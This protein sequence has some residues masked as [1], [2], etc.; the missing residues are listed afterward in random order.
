ML[1]TP[2]IAPDAGLVSLAERHLERRSGELPPAETFAARARRVLLEELEL[3]EPTLARL[4]ARLRMSERTVQRRLGDEGTSMQALLDDVRCEISLRQLAETTRT[5]AE[6]AYAVGFA[7][8]RA[9]HRA[10]KR[11]TG[12][13]PAAYRQPGPGADRPAA[14][15][16]QT[17][18]TSTRPPRRIATK[19]RSPSLA[20]PRG[21]QLPVAS[22]SIVPSSHSRC[23]LPTPASGR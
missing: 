11:W 4:A 20:I 21:S 8:V 23:T 15:D 13:T 5:I 9:F 22:V 17:G 12:S 18:S 19:A 14:R 7:E 3:G 2:H 16:S 1:D 10:F 6:I